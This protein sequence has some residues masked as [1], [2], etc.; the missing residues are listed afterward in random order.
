MEIGTP[1][2]SVD[3]EAL[4]A[5]IQATDGTA[6]MTEY[7]M[8]RRG[9][10]GKASGIVAMMGSAAIGYAQ[11]AHHSGGGVDSPPHWAIE[12]AVDPQQ[13]TPEV[14][15]SLVAAAAALVPTGERFVIWA[16]HRELEAALSRAG[17]RPTR[18]L[19]RL[20]CPLPVGATADAMPGV[21]VKPFAIGRDEKPWLAVNNAAFAGHPENGALTVGDLDERLR[22]PWFN[23]ADLLMAWEGSELL[24]SCW[25]KH[26]AD[27][28]GEIYIIGVSP[29]AQGRGLGR[30]LVI[31]GLEHL[32]RTGAVRGMLYVDGANEAAMWLYSDLGFRPVWTNRQYERGAE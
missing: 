24:G 13:R 2:D 31:H 4:F 20:E 21:V 16:W 6:A 1:T 18:E 25:T 19:H 30:G 10:R 22:R 32:Y 29:H 5:A 27:G 3:L 23:P 9:R 8:M 28:V 12:I 17:Y 14:Y 15:D 7:Q 11:V 26:H